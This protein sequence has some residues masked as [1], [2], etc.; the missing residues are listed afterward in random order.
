MD[1]RKLFAFLP[2]APAIIGA[3]IIKNS[4]EDEK[5]EDDMNG[6]IRIGF[7]KKREIKSSN[8]IFSAPELDHTRH[9][10]MSVGKDGNLWL[11]TANGD[12][13]RVVTE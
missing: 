1:R 7:V 6:T 8:M 13:K 12:W 10:S 3:S 4:N 2:L 11:K 5:P 9:V